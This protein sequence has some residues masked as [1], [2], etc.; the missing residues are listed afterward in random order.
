MLVPGLVILII[1]NYIPIPVLSLLLKGIASWKLY[2]QY[3]P[4]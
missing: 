1:N 3:F 4:K 2:E